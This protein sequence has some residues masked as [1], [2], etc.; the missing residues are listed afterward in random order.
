M[1]RHPLRNL[2]LPLVA[3]LVL[4]GCGQLLQPNVQADATALRAGDYQLD[5]QHA[6]LLWK[7]N[8]LG[9]SKYVGRFNEFDASLS[10]DPENPSAAQVAIVVQTA[11]LDVNF[12]QFEEDLR[13][14]SWFNVASYPDAS[15]E[16]TSADLDANGNGTVSG[17][18]TLLGVT[19]PVTFD[20]LFNGGARNPLTQNYTVGFEVNGVIKRSDFGMTNLLPAVGDEI[21]LEMHVEFLRE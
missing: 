4:I 15:F 17:N 13:G 14:T 6:V 12:P 10:Y 16:S 8:H 11:S 2:I 20:V 7:V 5:K 3:C 18:F 9:F 1:R 19:K 21:E